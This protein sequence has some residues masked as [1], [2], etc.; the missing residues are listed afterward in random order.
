MLLKL[1]QMIKIILGVL[2]G[3][4]LLDLFCAF[5]YNPTGYVESKTGATDLVREPGAFT[6][7]ATEGIAW[8]TIDANGYNNA[9]VPEDGDIFVLMMG[10]SHTEALNV[11]Q[12][13]SASARLEEMLRA[14]GRPGRVYNIGMS[15][16]TLVRNISNFG[17]ALD[18]FEPTG[19]VVVE[20]ADVIMYTS[21][22]VDAQSDALEPLPVT[23]VDM[24]GLLTDRPLMRTLYRQYMNLTGEERTEL[25]ADYIPEDTMSRY[26]AALIDAFT[27]L[28]AE[29]EA[30]GVELIIYYHP[31]LT[32]NFDGTVTPQTQGQCLEAFARACAAADVTFI[33]MTDVFLKA[34]SEDFTLPHGFANTPAGTGHLNADGHR[35]VAEALYDVISA[36]EAEK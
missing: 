23:G 21:S 35:M 31:H 29:A 24:P 32:L 27:M 9:A 4:V 26:E 14:N 28:R 7:R 5:Y 17:R 25:Y 33:D 15:S 36:R 30:H 18:E 22:L 13:E 34:Y 12:N 2:T 8:A 6:S 19:Y 10:S 11:M 16:H 1:K 3:V 20:T